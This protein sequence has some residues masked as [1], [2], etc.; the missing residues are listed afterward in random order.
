M[1]HEGFKP[2]DQSV[3]E[4]YEKRRRWLG[5]TFGDL[6]DRAADMFPLR[7][8][9]VTERVRLTYQ[10][11]R[12]SVDRVA[13]AFVEVGIQSGDKVLIQ[14]P[15]WEEFLFSFL[16]LHKIGAVAVLG[17]PRHAEREVEYLCDL[18][19]AVAW[20]VPCQYKKIEYTPLIKSIQSKSPHLKWTIVVGDHVPERCISFHEI[21]NRVRMEHYPNGYLA[22]FRPDPCDL[23]NILLTGGT[24]GLPKGV[25]RTHNDHICNGYYWM[26]A[27]ERT[28][29]DNCLIATPVGHNL[30]HVCAI[31]PMLIAG[32]RLTV[33]TSTAPKEIMEAIESEKVTCMT[34][35]PSQLAMLL[36]DPNLPK[37]DLS[38]LQSIQSGGAHVAPELVR[39]VYEKIGCRH[40]SNDFGMAEGPCSCTR[41][42][43]SEEIVSTTVGLPLCPYDRFKIIDDDEKEVPLGTEGELVAKGPGIFTGYY[44][45]DEENRKV[46]TPD[47]FFR[48]GD[49]GKIINQQGY[50]TITGRKKDIIIRGAENISATEV[51]ELIM[52]HPSVADTAVVG[53]PDTVLGERVCAFVKLAEGRTLSFEEMISHLRKKGASVLLLPERLELVEN[54]PLTKVGKIDKRA[55]RE[56]I[57]S[58]MK[59]EKEA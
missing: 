55:L 37:H 47:G 5:V 25:P 3:A 20:I 1:L 44:R 26:K 59:E 53:M 33:I 23:A 45:A 7:E 56:N 4:T 34:L 17:L 9:L 29:Y 24:T 38:S 50:L 28:S 21:S 48:T 58:R 22:Q 41:R 30:A 42:E 49:L 54:L 6:L 39:G 32:G 35:V 8:A 18:T 31:Y 43:D 16:A 40:F 11:F 19:K 13:L 36:N 12:Q 10:Q 15:N 46:F 27:W 14:L 57:A 51:E 2:Y 52:T